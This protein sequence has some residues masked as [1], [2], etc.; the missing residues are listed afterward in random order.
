MKD[1]RLLFLVILLSIVLVACGGGG[2]AEEAEAPGLQEP[3]S[4]EIA[5]DESSEPVQVRIGIGQ[6]P[7]TLNP[8]LA[9][10]S[11]TFFITNLVYDSLVHLE[12]DGSYS[13][14][15]AE[16]INISEDGS[17]VTVTLRDTVTF[18]DGEPLTADD[19]V[20]SFNLY[21]TQEDFPQM[22][23][24]TEQFLSVETLDEKTVV[25][26]LNDGL[27]N[28]E[29]ILSLLFVLPEHIWSQ[30]ENPSEFEN[31]EM[32][33][34]GPFKLADYR[35][36]EFVVLESIKD[37]YLDPPKIDGIV[38]QVFDNPDAMVQALKT[39]QVDMITELPNTAV[40]T[41]R[42]EDNVEV[43]NGPP[44][45]PGVTDL[46]INLSSE[47][48]CPPDGVCSGHQALQDRNVRRALAHAVDKQQI[49]ETVILGLGSPGFTLIPDGLGAFFN[50]QLDDYAFDTDLANQILDEAGYL[51]VDEDGIREL[52]G[53][54]ES[55]EF[56]M[57]WV[58]GGEEGARATRIAELIGATWEEIG[59]RIAPAAV[60][61]GVLLSLC[62]PALE[63]DL[64]IWGWTT[65]PDPGFLLSTMTTDQLGG[66]LSLNETGYSNPEYDQLY[67]QQATELDKAERIDIIHEM[68]DLVLRDL[69]YI[70]F[71]YEDRVQA[72]RT[73]AFTKVS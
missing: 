71:Y 65:T 29:A 36:D 63:H 27:P 41:L 52:P 24:Y 1:C 37:H 9:Q 66:D 13:L 10:L 42:N 46:I 40:A 32:I 2:E 7:D 17:V 55:L 26:T 44:L 14:G 70:P 18:H 67:H 68:Q 54:G 21:Q 19:V 28:L 25:I 23:L 56:T 12:L 34:A 35:Q 53:G 49:I 16:D 48:T 58:S 59:V 72:Y 33:G 30:V 6:G 45:D 15:L 60:D 4:E 20:Y 38:F 22:G 8:G 50:D 43:V 73:D 57:H 11:Y 64:I 47:K 69:P 3:A 39:S 5:E 61:E 31:R 62:C 51:D